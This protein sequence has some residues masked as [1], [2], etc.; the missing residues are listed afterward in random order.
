MVL[1]DIGTQVRVPEYSY[2][3][4]LQEESQWVDVYTSDNELYKD[5][6]SKIVCT[7]FNYNRVKLSHMS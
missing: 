4:I 5:I 6:R 2:Y 3:G 7:F 1:V